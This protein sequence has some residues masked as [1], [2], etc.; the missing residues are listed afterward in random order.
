MQYMQTQAQGWT[1]RSPSI[2]PSSANYWPGRS[3][4]GSP[5]VPQYSPLL[6]GVLRWS[7][8]Q[9]F[10]S[11]SSFFRSV[12]RAQGHRRGLEHRSTESFAFRLSSLL[13]TPVCC[14]TH[15]TEVRYN[16]R[17][18]TS[19]RPSFTVNCRSSETPS[20]LRTVDIFTRYFQESLSC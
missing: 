12:P 20:L 7:P 3:R 6:Q 1:D 11:A 10:V 8:V 9:S 15:Q 17:P 2:H 14:N 5:D 18:N 16:N 4:L 13:T 19:P